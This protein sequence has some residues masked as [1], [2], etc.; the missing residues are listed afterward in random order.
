MCKNLYDHVFRDKELPTYMYIFFQIQQVLKRGANNC[1]FYIFL[2]SEGRF[3][4]ATT[5]PLRFDSRNFT[6]R[7]AQ[8]T[9][10]WS[11]NS[12]NKLGITTHQK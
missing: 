4:S 1:Q 12:H 5:T 6:H 3:L 9:V 10:L 8:M 11:P 2:L 7:V